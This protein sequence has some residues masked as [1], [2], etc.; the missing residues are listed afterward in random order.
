[1]DE[2]VWEAI[3][4]SPVMI[5]VVSSTGLEP[6]TAIEVGAARAWN[7]SILVV[8]TDPSTVRVPFDLGAVP[9]FTLGRIEDLVDAI[10]E[11]IQQLTDEDRHS[12]ANIYGKVGVAVDQ[13][14]FDPVARDDLVKRFNKSSGKN[15]PGERLLS[16]L[17]RL[18]KKGALPKVS[19]RRVGS[20]RRGTA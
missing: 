8:V 4:E 12:L 13:L 11:S 5:V 20:A 18:R 10:R 1:M 17:L 6:K 14:A 2:V 3:A 9:V 16:E 19:A 7:K 15:L